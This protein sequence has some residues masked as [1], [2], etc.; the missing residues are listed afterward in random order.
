[1]CREIYIKILWRDVVVCI[2]GDYVGFFL[3]SFI[4]RRFKKDLKIFGWN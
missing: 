1:M 2:M 3:G 4:V